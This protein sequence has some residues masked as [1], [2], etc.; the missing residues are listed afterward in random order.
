[1]S[2][3]SSYGS[4]AAPG[5]TPLVGRSVTVEPITDDR[6]FGEL[7]AAYGQPDN[8]TLFDYL[9]YGPFTAAEAF[10]EWA[11]RTYLSGEML[12]HALVPATSG[13]AASAP[14]GSGGP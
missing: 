14:A 8:E 1:M 2:A 3:L 12:F 7:F 10:S 5:T 11:N 9:P 6:R 4:R 13:R